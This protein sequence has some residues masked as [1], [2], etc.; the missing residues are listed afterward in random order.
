MLLS[1]D[2]FNCLRLLTNIH[3]K[4]HFEFSKLGE[5]GGWAG[6]NK[7]PVYLGP[8]ASYLPWARKDNPLPTY[9]SIKA[10]KPATY[11]L[12]QTHSRWTLVSVG[13]NPQ[14]WA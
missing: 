2:K 11:F 7:Y 1:R 10:L 4:I 5:K 3:T 9:L 14:P 8:Y 12:P 6:I 13:P